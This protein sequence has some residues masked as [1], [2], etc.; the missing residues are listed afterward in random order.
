MSTTKG[1]SRNAKHRTKRTAASGPPRESFDILP[2]PGPSFHGRIGSTYEDS[3]P[4]VIQLA[5]PPQGAPNVLLVLLD[6]VGFGQASTFGGPANT[7]TLQRLADD[8]LRYNRFHTTALCSP[9]RAA[10][11]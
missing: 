4:D 2:H 1:A 9:T 8:G 10:L 7:P 6:D 11:L 5:T 3:E